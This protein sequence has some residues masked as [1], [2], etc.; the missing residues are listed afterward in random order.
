MPTK[1]RRPCRT[2]GCA[3]LAVRGGYC[4]RCARER[5]R[6]FDRQRGSS[7]ARG[8]GSR[9]RKLRLMYLRAHPLCA[10][11]GEPATDV[12]HIVPRG[13]GGTDAGDN[14]QSLCKPHPGEKPA[15]EVGGRGG[16]NR[17]DNP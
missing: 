6:A 4:E 7:A 8:Y 10:V 1:A 17:G 14:L 2:P 5:E 3:G 13:R 15:D 11:C 16:A 12:D 9:W